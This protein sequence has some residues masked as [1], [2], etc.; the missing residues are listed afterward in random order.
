[1]PAPRYHRQARADLEALWLHIAPEN[2]EAADRYLDGLHEA[3]GRYAEHPGMGRLEPE[4]AERLHVPA[5][6][7]LR[8]FLHRNYRCYYVPD[9][10]GI[11]I[12]RVIDTRRDIDTALGE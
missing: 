2:L 3:A 12:L 7:T 10:E 6:I 5:G 11:F 9:E 8:S 4:L 1:M